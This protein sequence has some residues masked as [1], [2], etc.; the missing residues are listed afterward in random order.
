MRAD[1]EVLRKSH[2]RAIPG[3]DFPRAIRKEVAGET[4]RKKPAARCIR[5]GRMNPVGSMPLTKLYLTFGMV[6]Y[7]H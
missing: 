4:E 3:K 6:R 2:R 5:S 7:I 1:T